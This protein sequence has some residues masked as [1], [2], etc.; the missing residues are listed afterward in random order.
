MRRLLLTRLSCSANP[1]MFYNRT[2][3]VRALSIPFDKVHIESVVSR[4][5]LTL[6]LFGL[7]PFSVLNNC[8]SM[9]S[10]VLSNLVLPFLQTMLPIILWISSTFSNDG[11]RLLKLF[12]TL[13]FES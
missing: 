11:V 4:I 12:S 6:R 10:S 1:S 8:F 13:I 2:Q 5:I 9:L 7:I 3:Y